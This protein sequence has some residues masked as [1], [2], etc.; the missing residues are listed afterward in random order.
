MHIKTLLII[1]ANVAVHAH[2]AQTK[3]KRRLH[4]RRYFPPV[5]PANIHE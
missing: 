1:H 4:L 3:L 5:T 2:L